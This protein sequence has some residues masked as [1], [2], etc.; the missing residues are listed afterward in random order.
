MGQDKVF[1]NEAAPFQ[2][3]TDSKIGHN[4]STIRQAR[5]GYK[6]F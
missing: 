3:G 5:R 2:N 4:I 6:T 1:Q